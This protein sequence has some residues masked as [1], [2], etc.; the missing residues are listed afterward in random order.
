MSRILIVSGVSGSGK[1]TIGEQLSAR[2]NVP[3]YD[4]DAFHP[5]ANIDKMKAGHPLNDEDRKPWL[6]AM[7]S[8]MQGWEENQGAVLGCSALKEK[9][10]QTLQQGATEQIIWIM[11]EG[12][13]ELIKARMTKRKNHFFDADMLQSQ[14]DAYERPDYGYFFDVKHSPKV[15]VDNIVNKLKEN[16]EIDKL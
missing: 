7:A 12:K 13:F 11:L 14:Y 6:E 2:I 1:T 15:I 16:Y 10:R 5:Q 3:F 8:A 9:Y 4:A